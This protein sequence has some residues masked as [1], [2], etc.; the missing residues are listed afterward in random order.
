MFGATRR[1]P[2]RCEKPCSWLVMNSSSAAFP[3]SF[4]RR[5]RRIASPICAGSSTRSLQPPR[6][7]ADIGVV[8]AEVACPVALVRQRHRVGLDRHRRVVEHDRRDRDAAAHRRLEIEP[9]HPEGGVAHEVDAELVGRGDLGADDEAE[10]GAELMRLAPADIAARPG[11]PVERDELVARAA[12]IVGDDGLGG[13]DHPHELRDHPVGVDRPLVRAQLG[14]PAAEPCLALARELLSDAVASAPCRRAGRA[15][16]RS[17][18]PAPAWR[19]RGCRDRQRR[20]CSG[21]AC[22]WSRG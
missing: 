19:R 22:R 18:A 21:R 3:S 5:A 12:G 15:P 20:P 11:R 2:R 8:A 1:A 4:C 9:G 13:I 10:P 16:P 14:L 17:I 7:R 6:S